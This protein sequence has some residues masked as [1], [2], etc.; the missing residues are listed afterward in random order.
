MSNIIEFQNISKFYPGVIANDDISFSIKQQSIHAILGENGAGKSTLVKIL[1]GH[2]FHDSGQI[3][4]NSQQVEI[5]NPFDAKKLGI[6][7]VFQH[8]SLF[9]SLSVYENLILGIDEN[10]SFKK[11]KE[12]TIEICNKYGFNLNLDSPISSLS[13]GERQTVE[14]VR[15]LLNNP[16]ILIL[17]EPT[18]VLT[19]FEIE[20]LFNII[21]KL[22]KDG[23]TVLFISHKLEE[24]INLT[25][26]VTILRSGK[27]IGTY[28]TH[29]ETPESL[30]LKMLGYEVPALN[31]KQVINSDKSIFEIKNLSTN[32][33]DPFSVNL[34]DINLQIKKGEIMGIAGVAGNGQNELMDILTNES[35]ENFQGE[36]IFKNINISKLS[37]FE[38][39]KLSISFV[40]EQR[41]GH[42]AVPEMTLEENVLLSLNY[43]SDFS[44]NDLINFD[45]IS[46][47][48]KKIIKEFN[49][50]APSSISKA[51]ELSG[52]NLQ[53]FIIGRE[54]LSNPDLLIL[55]QPTWGIDVGSESFIRKS[56][57]ELSEKGI[58]I[59]IISHDIE[60]LIE[61]CHQISVIYQGKLSKSLTTEN[62]DMTQL[63]KYMGGLFD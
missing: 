1:Y 19:P 16:K 20:R 35:D 41:L 43:K 58:S 47:Y 33:S 32:Y 38:R 11:L 57:L 36:I 18:S 8:F 23:L 7:M 10:L 49:V 42:S 4:I 14:I 9:E 56:L 29:Q 44:K 48:T 25:N 45:N 62:V 26:Y 24:I 63:G 2:S 31:K 59:L 40:T 28:E 37:T 21:K 6:N 54:I 30:G 55:S 12:N 22:V 52:G 3:L 60:E 50:S 15:A 53:K 5:K 13:V 51:G 61:L 39:R 34:K 46:D 27:V 17:D